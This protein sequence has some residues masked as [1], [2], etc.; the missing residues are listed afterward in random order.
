[1]VVMIGQLLQLVD[2]Q[3]QPKETSTWIERNDEMYTTAD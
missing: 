1:M 2:S 3:L